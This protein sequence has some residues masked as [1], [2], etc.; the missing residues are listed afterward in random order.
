VERPNWIKSQS[1]NGCLKQELETNC[2]LGE[3]EIKI[4]YK[5]GTILDHCVLCEYI[6]E[7]ILNVEASSMW[8]RK[9][10]RCGIGKLYWL[11]CV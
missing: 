8:Y 3:I 11:H 6:E 5:N 1:R 7:K 9:P 4:S 2:M 10:M